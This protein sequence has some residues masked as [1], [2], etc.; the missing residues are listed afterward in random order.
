MVAECAGK[1]SGVFFALF[2]E[3][4]RKQPFPIPADDEI[5]PGLRA[6]LASTRRGSGRTCRSAQG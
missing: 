2:Y 3:L 1:F 5:D 4:W 6:Q